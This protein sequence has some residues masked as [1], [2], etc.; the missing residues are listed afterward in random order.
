MSEWINAIYAL[1]DVDQSVLVYF[2][3]D[4]ERAVVNVSDYIR[5]CISGDE[6]SPVWNQITHWMPLPAPPKK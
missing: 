2:A 1:P 5:A 3:D 6:Y 4:N